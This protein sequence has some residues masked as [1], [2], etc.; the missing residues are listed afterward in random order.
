[1]RLGAAKGELALALIFVLT[2]AF[3]II[4]AAGMPLWDGFAPD[5]GFLPLA[6]GVLL[7]AISIV[8]VAQLLAGTPAAVGADTRKP[9]LVLAALAVTVAI[10]PL[11]GFAISV[12]LLM[13]FLYAVLE[14][15]P[16]VVATLASGATSGVLY[17]IFKTWLGVPLP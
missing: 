10:L 12:F 14:R 3:W 1:M 15:L 7:A 13:L 9:L 6:Y 8:V 5:S 16:L 4:R 2:G 17:L 11:A